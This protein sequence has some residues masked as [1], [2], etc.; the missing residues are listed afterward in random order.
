ML[1]FLLVQIFPL[2]MLTAGAMDV[3][4]FKIPNWLSIVL[5]IGFLLTA[6]ISASPLQLVLSHLL[7]GLV[8]L[9][10]GFGMFTQG[11]VG[12]G[13]AKLLA[14]AALWF[15]F[16]HLLPFLL[17][18]TMLGGVLALF[19]ITYRRVLP[20]LWLIRQPWAMRLHDSREGIPYGVAL[21]GASL[22]VYPQTIWM[23]GIAG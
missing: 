4:S 23:T 14:A 13:D 2:A 19:L 15:G 16:E 11:W 7:A 5:F 10:L 9:L 12:G 6:Q 8:I 22:I 21:A 18:T 1:Q 3:L 20:P 17:W